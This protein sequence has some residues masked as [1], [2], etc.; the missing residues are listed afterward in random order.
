MEPKVFDYHNPIEFLNASLVS[1]R[2][3][4]SSF[5][6][7]AWAKQLGLSHVAMLSMVLGQK[8]KLLPNLSSK[9]S[10]QFK[11]AGRFSEAEAR[12]FEILVLFHNA[13]TIEEKNFYGGILAS[14]KPDQRFSTL[15]LDKLN[16]IADWYYSV[17]MEM[18]AVKNFKSDPRWICLKLGGSVNESQVKAAIDRLIRLGLLERNEKGKLFRTH[19]QIA[20]PTD[21]P[22]KSLRK[23][24]AEMMTKATLALENQ[25][26]EKRDI[27]SFTF[28]IDTKKIPKAKKM[29]R[30]FRRTLAKFLETPD[31]DSVYQLNIQL[32]DLLGE[33]N[34]KS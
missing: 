17:I 7:R 16:V 13:Q 8:R 12:Y 26:V 33:E 20:T 1:A 23:Y 2:A 9:I 25:P 3:R 29:I 27:T 31:G 14:V 32:F 4:N 15:D 34:E 30:D 11:D 22:D 19:A 28:T 18:T 10:A 6:M 21:I 24:H 5:S